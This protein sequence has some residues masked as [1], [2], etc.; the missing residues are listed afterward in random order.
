M[1]RPITDGM[2]G[3]PQV[4]ALAQRLEDVLGAGPTCARSGRSRAGSTGSR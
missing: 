3:A 4:A 2:L 1:A